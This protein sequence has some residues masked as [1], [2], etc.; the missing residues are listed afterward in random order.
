MGLGTD[1]IS[2]NNTSSAQG[3]T[4]TDNL[5]DFLYGSRHRYLGIM[6][7]FTNIPKSTSNGGLIDH[8]LNSK[9]TI[10][11]F[12]SISLDLH[13]FYLQSR[14]ADKN[15]GV[16][17]ATSLDPFLGNELDLLYDLKLQEDFAIQAAYCIMLPQE[18]MKIIDGFNQSKTGFS[19]W[20]YLLLTVKP[21]LFSKN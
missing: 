18:S 15:S 14:V 5:F 9:L 4:G 6:D 10:N 1:I 20:F 12:N 16:N 17:E 8:Y 13:Y 11:K 7:Y 3:N 2:G 21:S 19:Y